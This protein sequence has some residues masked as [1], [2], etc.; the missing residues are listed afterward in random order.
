MRNLRPSLTAF[1]AVLYV[2]LGISAAWHAPHFSRGEVAVGVDAH[3]ETHENSPG[4][5]D[6]ALCTWK[7]AS[8][9]SFVS[10]SVAPLAHTVAPAT[11]PVP[12]VPADGCLRAARARAPPLL[13]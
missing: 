6:C 7:T 2:L 3:A 8:Q 12:K 13:S 10:L 9:E 11:R 5:G 4:D 1:A